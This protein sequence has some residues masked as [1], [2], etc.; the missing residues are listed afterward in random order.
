[1]VAREMGLRGF[2]FSV[3]GVIT[4]CLH[5]DGKNFTE[6]ENVLIYIGDRDKET[7]GEEK[8]R[9]YRSKSLKSTK[10]ASG[11]EM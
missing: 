10:E 7:K 8:G 6:W 4:S 1:M 2:C 9:N 3:L 5:A 11:E